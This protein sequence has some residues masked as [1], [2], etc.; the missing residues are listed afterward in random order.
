MGLAPDDQRKRDQVVE[1]AHAEEGKPYARVAR[2]RA[3]GEAQEEQKCG[4]RQADPQCDDGERRQ[5]LDRDAD[6]EKRTAPQ[7]G[8]GDQHGP[9]SGSHELRLDCFRHLHTLLT[10]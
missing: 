5:R 6:E 9:F 10:I 1:Q 7:K 4:R 8:Q 3:P 2:H